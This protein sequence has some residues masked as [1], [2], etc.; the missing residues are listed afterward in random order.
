MGRQRLLKCRDIQLLLSPRKTMNYKLK[1]KVF[2]LPLIGCT[3]HSSHPWNSM[4]TNSQMDS[5]SIYINVYLFIHI[6]ILSICMYIMHVNTY[7]H[8]NAHILTYDTNNQRPQGF[9]LGFL[10][11]KLSLIFVGYFLSDSLFITAYLWNWRA[12][13]F[14]CFQQFSVHDHIMFNH[15]LL[16][17]YILLCQKWVS[18]CTSH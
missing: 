8:T 5:V 10:L 4:H 17:I 11:K 13:F 6:H 15:G 16:N 2:T 1:T 14:C 9:L 7:I 18:I 12:I 3:V